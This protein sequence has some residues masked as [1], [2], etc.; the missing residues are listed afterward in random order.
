MMKV[1]FSNKT[2]PFLK[3][4]HLTCCN[5]GNCIYVISNINTLNI[6]VGILYAFTGSFVAHPIITVRLETINPIKLLPASPRKIDAG[7][8]YL[9]LYGKNPSEIHKMAIERNIT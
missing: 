5:S 9:K 7:L 8:L 4:L 2:Y 1:I 6:R 3:C